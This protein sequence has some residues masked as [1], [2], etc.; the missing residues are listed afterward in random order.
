MDPSPNSFR[1]NAN[2]LT[3]SGEDQSPHH[4]GFGEDVDAFL[5]NDEDDDENMDEEDLIE[6]NL[7][8]KME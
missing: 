7:P 1:S 6:D 2:P 5:D 4:S 3:F 8:L